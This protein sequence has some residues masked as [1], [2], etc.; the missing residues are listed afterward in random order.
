MWVQGG[1]FGGFY[2]AC[3]PFYVY[4]NIGAG[5]SSGQLPSGSVGRRM[6]VIT[7]PSPT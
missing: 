7:V 3:L 5:F 2:V 4:Y 6:A 1:M